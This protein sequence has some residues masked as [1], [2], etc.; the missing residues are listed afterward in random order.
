MAIISGNLG[1]RLAPSG[2]GGGTF[3]FGSLLGRRAPLAALPPSIHP[4]ATTPIATSSPPIQMTPAIAQGLA[5]TMQGAAIVA[6]PSGSSSG[7]TLG[8]PSPSQRSMPSITPGM[9]S[10]ISGVANDLIGRGAVVQ[11]GPTQGRR[12]NLGFSSTSVTSLATTNAESAPQTIFRP[13]R[14]FIPSANTASFNVASV[15]IG[16]LNQFVNDKA[17]PSAMF[18]ELAVNADVEYDTSPAAVTIAVGLTS[19]DTTATRSTTPGM[20][21]R[22]AY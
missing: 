21:G 3:S 14:L 5:A 18:S 22:S 12:Q 13:D 9:A 11:S 20:T 16:N 1:S 4:V 15:V 6:Q 17:C 7:P 10:A 19:L 2:G 8:S